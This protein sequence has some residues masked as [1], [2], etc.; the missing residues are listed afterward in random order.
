M[1]CMA[2]VD[3]LL[4]L[5]RKVKRES[6][7]RADLGTASRRMKARYL[8]QMVISIKGKLRKINR[9]DLEILETRLGM[10]GVF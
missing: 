6:F 10:G 5:I 4:G 9:H 3:L 1:S 8:T 2:R 7:M